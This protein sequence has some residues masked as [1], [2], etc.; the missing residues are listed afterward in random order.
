VEAGPAV[1]RL[2]LGDAVTVQVRDVETVVFPAG[3]DATPVDV[4]EDVLV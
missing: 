3:G 4:P 1:R 2:R